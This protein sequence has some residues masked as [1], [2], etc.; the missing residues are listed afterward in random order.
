[1][2]VE[3][4]ARRYAAA[5]ADVVLKQGNAREV[6]S[7][8]Q[9]WEEMMTANPQLLEVF[10]NPTIPYQ[11][12]R[13]V[14]DTL[15]ARARPMQTTANVLQV[16]LQNARLADLSAVNRAFARVLDERA[17]MITARVTTAHSISTQIQDSLRQRLSDITKKG[18]NLNFHVDES[19]I[20]GIITQIGST[21][22]DGSVRNQ[23]QLAKEQMLGEAA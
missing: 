2:S 21:V 5:L 7:E 9:A 16:L 14:L 3:T 13:R 4:V 8:L 18:V 22:Y 15:I 19:I 20:G 10:R 23:L 17:G 12:K 6:Q 11:D 1:M